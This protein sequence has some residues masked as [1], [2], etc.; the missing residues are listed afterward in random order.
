MLYHGENNNVSC[1]KGTME[2]K[3]DLIKGYYGCKVWCKEAWQWSLV[4]RQRKLEAII[5]ECGTIV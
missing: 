2:G 4:I 3:V 5:V 1:T